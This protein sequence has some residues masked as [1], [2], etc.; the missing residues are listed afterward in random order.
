M[1]TGE[2]GQ[3]LRI[4]RLDESSWLWDENKDVTLG[5]LDLKPGDRE[6]EAYWCRDAAPITRIKYFTHL[7]PAAPL[8]WL[9]VQTASTT[10]ILSPVYHSV[11][12][13]YSHSALGQLP[14]SRVDP[15][16][17]LTMT[18]EHT[19]GRSHVDVDINPPSPDTPLQIAVIDDHGGWSVWNVKGDMTPV[20]GSPPR[21][22]LHKRGTF[23]EVVPE[24]QRRGFGI[25]WYRPP[26]DPGGSLF[27]QRSTDDDKHKGITHPGL[28]PVLAE[29]SH[30]LLIWNYTTIQVVNTNTGAAI[31]HIP[32]TQ[33]SEDKEIILQVRSNPSDPSQALVLTTH[34]IL[35]LN[36]CPAGE[37]S[38]DE[39]P[40]I[41]H[42]F[43]HDHPGN[44]TLQLS[45]S[46]SLV[47]N[48]TSF[49][50]IFPSDGP[51]ASVFWFYGATDSGLGQFSHQV[52]Y[53][54]RDESPELDSLHTLCIL[55]MRLSTYHKN[56]PRGPG[57][58][59][60]HLNVEFHQVVSLGRRQSMGYW[61]CATAKRG[62]G[63]ILAP[64]P[65]KPIG[66]DA[67][68]RGNPQVTKQVKRRLAYTR[69][70]DDKFVVPDS[71]E[72]VEG[73]VR[74]QAGGEAR[75]SSDTWV[76]FTPLPSV[77][78][79]VLLRRRFYPH[80]VLELY[81]EL[82]S[83]GG[84]ALRTKS[85]EVVRQ[86][87]Q[88]GLESDENPRRSLLECLDLDNMRRSM[89]GRAENASTTTADDEDWAEELGQ[90]IDA[91]L[92]V[93]SLKDA[94]PNPPWRTDDFREKLLAMR[95]WLVDLW[96]APPEDTYPEAAAQRRAVLEETAVLAV[97]AYQTIDV[98]APSLPG[99]GTPEL[100]SSQPDTLPYVSQTTGYP[101]SQ[102]LPQQLPASS[103]PLS[104]QPS[105]SQ[106]SAS[107]QQARQ[108]AEQE[109]SR[110]AIDRLSR[111]ATKIDSNVALSTLSQHPV[112]SRWE[113]AGSEPYTAFIEKP[114]AAVQ[115]K[116]KRRREK[117]VERRKAKEASFNRLTGRD[118]ASSQDMG[119]SLGRSRE[120]LSQGTTSIPLRV[121][122]SS[123]RAGE[124]MSSQTQP[125]TMSQPVAG[126]F[127]QRMGKKKKKKGGIK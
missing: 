57:A 51:R 73:L 56:A 77:Q 102:P 116:L 58:M 94:H 120:P 6:E 98:N 37:D 104:S 99:R 39:G 72:D 14:P 61:I 96:P 66:A 36:I 12:V 65:R 47:D 86:M 78:R 111:L 110:A 75:G 103:Q 95:D 23:W 88:E 52:Q 62:I 22:T 24:E 106:P 3:I 108:V 25:L 70:M 85:L 125:V 113:E 43:L 21:L 107:Q 50:L 87:L 19:A 124:L 93:F 71:F 11:P 18:L 121:K 60:R 100:P 117:M 2:G 34:S 35:L 16:E 5:A 44:P 17:V 32:I 114:A 89:S 122:G 15:N 119:A 91:G 55:P 92:G 28:A 9:V 68:P 29:R 69:Y 67:D 84:K 53:L 10:T 26:R 79:E 20:V 49:G 83:T 63:D 31:G 38:P 64:E 74:P 109:A 105:S 118:V 30:T 7:P 97:L 41:I 4:L 80:V 8:R 123:S 40:S 76:D 59:Y 101:W 27:A 90:I 42:A 127:G 126:A 81:R 13:S 48:G 33:R 45:V 54:R 112:L 115:E 82:L 46:R 1:V